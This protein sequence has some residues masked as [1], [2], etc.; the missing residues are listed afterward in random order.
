MVELK[1]DN[2]YTEKKTPNLSPSTTYFV[3]SG[4]SSF[5]HTRQIQLPFVIRT[6]IEKLFFTR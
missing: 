3:M 1:L 4:Y 2:K 6:D 5:L